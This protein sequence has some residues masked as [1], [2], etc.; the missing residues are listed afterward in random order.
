MAEKEEP[1]TALPVAGSDGAAPALDERTA[2]TVAE[3]A[4]TVTAFADALTPE[5]LSGLMRMT[6][7]LAALA[8]R[9]ARP[10][11]AGLLDRLLEELPTLERLLDRV[12][13]MEKDGGLARVEE[14]LGFLGTAL[15]AS[16][17]ELVGSLARTLARL[18]EVADQL[19]ESELFR[20][21]PA[22]LGD[23]DRV[24]RQP[25]RHSPRGELRHL[26]ARLRDPDVQDGLELVLEVLRRAGRGA[27]EEAMRRSSPEPA[28]S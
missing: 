22:A 26:M 24:L 23:V 4:G 5:T 1:E 25:P 8:D 27:R 18:L 17:P 7:E 16:T 13:R 15:S 20:Q 11:V 6:S 14:L 9:L 21:L 3:L 28:G 10:E 2:R 12:E 19:M